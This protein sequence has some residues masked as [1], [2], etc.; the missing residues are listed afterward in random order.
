MLYKFG[1]EAFNGSIIAL[2]TNRYDWEA[3]RA[4]TLS[5]TFEVCT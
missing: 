3:A 5:K 2:A 4:G 1:L